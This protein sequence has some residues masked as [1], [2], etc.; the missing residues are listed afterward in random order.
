M[1]KC[2]ICNSELYCKNVRYFRKDNKTFSIIWQSNIGYIKKDKIV[3]GY[4]YK[5]RIKDSIIRIYRCKNCHVSNKTKL[6]KITKGW[7]ISEHVEPDIN[8]GLKGF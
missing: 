3:N 2:D 6:S 4:Y 8:N 1:L 5:Q 7:N